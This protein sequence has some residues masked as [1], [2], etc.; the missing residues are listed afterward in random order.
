VGVPSAPTQVYRRRRPEIICSSRDATVPE[1]E[2]QNGRPTVRMC[3]GAT[4][5]AVARLS[6]AAASPTAVGTLGDSRG[7]FLSPEISG[8]PQGA[9][10]LRPTRARRRDHDRDDDGVARL[11]TMFLFMSPLLRIAVKLTGIFT[12]PLSTE[13]RGL[14]VGAPR[15]S[16]QR[17]RNSAGPQSP[18]AERGL[19]STLTGH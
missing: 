6:R 15:I 8:G 3:A 12:A 10:H 5:D 19:A 18:F 7:Y 4:S 17:S 9:A 13:I 2:R 14:P 11:Q 16:W 1:A